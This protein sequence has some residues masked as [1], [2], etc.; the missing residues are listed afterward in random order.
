MSNLSKLLAQ[1]GALA[2]Q[3]D[4]SGALAIFEKAVRDHAG[5][6]EPWIS[7]SAVYGM[8]GNYSEALRCARKAVELSP[9]SLQGWVNLGSAAESCGDLAQAAEAFQHASQ[10]PG[11]PPEITL[12]WGLAL[13][14]S[15]KWAEAEKPLRTY[16]A[17]QPGH[18]EATFTLARALAIKGNIEAISMAEEYCQRNRDDVQA[19]SRLATIYL[20]LGKKDDA[21]RVC[22][23]ATMQSPEGT[24]VLFFKAGLL[25]FEGRYS[26]ARDVYEQLI[27][28]QP[29]NPQPLTMMANVCQ[30]DGDMQGAIAYA[31]AALKIEPRSIDALSTLSTAVMNNNPVEARQL[32]EQA[33]AIAP[34]DLSLKTLQGR[35]LEFEG[36]KQG[37]WECVRSALEAGSLNLGAALVA[38]SVAPDVGK[39]EEAISIL[40]RFVAQAGLSSADQKTIR[41]ALV[42][43]CDKAKQYDRAFGHAILANK[44]KNVWHD[45]NANTREV[46]RLKFVYSASAISSLPYSSVRSGLPI[47]IVGMP[48]SGTSLMEQ[49]LSCHSK[50]HARGETTDVRKV[51][52]GIPYYPDGVRNLAQ[53]KLD[54]LANAYIQ[55]LRAMA[56]LATRVTDKLPGNYM[57]AGFI[58][59]LFP[60]AR[61]VHCQRDARDVC[62]SNYFTEF[63]VGHV[64]TYNLESLAQT[65]KDYQELMEHW[66]MVLPIPILNVRYEELVAD[67]RVWIERILDFCGLEWEDACLNFHQS[68]RQVATASYD[69]VRR[70]LYKS[71]VARWKHYARHLEPVS[72]ILGL[73]DDV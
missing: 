7:L 25:T 57:Y 12:Q 59:Q 66:N 30:Q 53:E 1:G 50:V 4:I 64:H 21:W 40:E 45:T 54:A 68:K 73:K 24:D 51:A 44:L 35:M 69:Q 65:Y 36:N 56:P 23:Q 20:E 19:L 42:K 46:N 43:I 3:N 5:H 16:L 41:F 38:A 29:G 9:K 26:E 61:I 63:A 22:N 71:S 47:F 17:R 49:I 34:H 33:L 10:L 55:R 72:R 52:E 15:G 28:L 58:S 37:A 18:R 62:L 67:P 14:Q 8:N 48:R 70:P 2:R 6:S 32:M 13:T 11:C 39:M 27:R 60:D 31:R